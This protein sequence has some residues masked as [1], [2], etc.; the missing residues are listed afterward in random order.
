VKADKDYRKMVEDSQKEVSLETLHK[1]KAAT[2]VSDNIMKLIA[3]ELRTDAKVQPGLRASL[4]HANQKFASHF[5]VEEVSNPTDG[6][7]FPIVF[8]KDAE[9]FFTSIIDNRG[10][11]H[12]D[13]ILRLSIDEGR[14]F[15]KV[16]I[17]NVLCK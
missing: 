14:S 5:Q 7:K 4:I 2:G 12:N 13:V 6:T 8:C 9:S 15:L 10:V 1:V 3:R 11:K 16:N 17:E